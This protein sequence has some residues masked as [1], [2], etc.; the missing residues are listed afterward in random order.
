RPRR[1]SPRQ[2]AI[3]R[4]R[5]LLSQRRGLSGMRTAGHRPAI[6]G[7]NLGGRIAAPANPGHRPA[8]AL[9]LHRGSGNH[10]FKDAS[11][12]GT[13]PGMPV[14]KLTDFFKTVAALFA[15]VFVV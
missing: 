6:P 12:F 10:L 3:W 5:S 9:E 7:G 13:L 2:R 1:T 15:E 4:G 8:R 14:G 11:A